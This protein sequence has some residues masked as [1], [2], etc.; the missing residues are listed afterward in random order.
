MRHLKTLLTVIGA[1]TVLVL[2]ANTVALA[3]TGQGFILG[4]SNSANKVTKLSR[5]TSGSVL[6]LHSKSAANAPLTVNG[7]GKVT[8]LNADLLDGLDSTSLRAKTYIYSLPSQNLVSVMNVI[9]SSLPSGLYRG[10]YN[11]TMT[12]NGSANPLNCY[13]TYSD[14]AFT[15]I[16]YGV[17]LS[18]FSTSQDSGVVDTRNGRK[19][20]LHCYFFGSGSTMTTTEPVPDVSFTQLNSVSSG[21]GTNGTFPRRLARH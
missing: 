15:A 17:Y 9:F 16:N 7:R 13:F 2:A 19:V 8:N 4:A 21:T 14:H 1:V 12:V 11:V 6:S 18:G 10:T 5:T 20:A 3:A